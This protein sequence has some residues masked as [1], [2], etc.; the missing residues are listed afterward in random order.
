[1]ASSA[2]LDRE[3]RSLTRPDIDPQQALGVILGQII[4]GVDD[5]NGVYSGIRGY[6]LA[7]G[8]YGNYT[9]YDATTNTSYAIGNTAPFTAG[10]R[11]HYTYPGNYPIPALRNQDD[12]ALVNFTYFPT[13]GFLRD[14]ERFGPRG[15]LRPANSNDTRTDYLAAFAVPYTY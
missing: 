15:S 10:G 7:R 2:R 5:E 13:D 9:Y 8:V 12:W 6:D 3:T 4:Y 11:T 14:P 1:E